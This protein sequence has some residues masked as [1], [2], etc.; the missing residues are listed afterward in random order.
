MTK[1]LRIATQ[2]LLW[3]LVLALTPL[4]V[5]SLLTYRMS[6]GLLMDQIQTNLRAIASNLGEEVESHLR[7]QERDL[8]VLAASASTAEALQAFGTAWT[9]GTFDEDAFSAAAARFEPFLVHSADA[10]GAD[11]IYLVGPDGRVVFS[12]A[13]GPDFGA[14]LESEEWRDTVLGRTANS[15]LVTLGIEQSDLEFYGPESV[16]ATFLASPVFSEGRLRGLIVLQVGAADLNRV[17][18][19]TTG[20]GETGEMVVVSE[21]NDEIVV[22]APTRH[23]PDAAFTRKISREGNQSTAIRESVDGHYGAGLGIDYRGKR[24]VASW[25]YLPALRWGVVVKIDADEAFAPIAALGRLST[26]IAAI[27]VVLA[28]VAAWLVARSFSRP[29]E[30]LTAAVHQV[31]SG[32]LRR[33]VNVRTRNEIGRLAEDFNQMTAQLREMVETMD[34][35]VRLRTAELAEARD[36]AEQANR[37]KSAFLANMSHELRTPMNAI[38]GYSEMLIEECED[39][40]HDEFVPDLQKIRSAGKH[41]L[42]LINDVL[43]LSKIEAGKMTIYLEDFAIRQ[44]LDEV[45]STIQPLIEKNDNRLELR[46]ASDLGSM[47]ADLTKVRQTL[48]NLLSN[49]SKFTEKGTVTLEV[50]RVSSPTGDRIILRVSDTGIG[51]T[52]E[53]LGKLFEAFTQADAST[54]RKYGGTGLGLAISREFCRMMG[55]DIT[56]ESELGKGSTFTVELPAEVAESAGQ[57]SPQSSQTASAPSAGGEGAILVI[58][59]DP[60]AADL[61]RR[62]LEKCGHRVLVATSGMEGLKMACEHKPAAITLDVM[63]PGMDGWSVL[64][65][66]KSDPATVDIPVVMVSLVRDKQ[67]GFTL[68][69]TDFLTKPV[70]ANQL[71][72][73]LGRLVGDAPGD[74]LVVE[75]D[76][77]SREMLVRLLGKSGFRVR[78]AENGALGLEAVA[79][80]R[81]A[82]ILLDLMMPVMDGF[83]FLAAIRQDSGMADIPVIIVTAKDLTEQDHQRLNGSAEAIIQKSSID[84]ATLL[85]RV[86]AIIG[87]K[88]H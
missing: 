36:L 39:L 43:D 14:D 8:N 25:Q 27:T 80:A 37:T 4:T 38:I 2:L 5:A 60:N 64:A 10:L 74:A 83:E 70:D 66:L 6:R 48:F 50:E 41:L 3:F 85:D 87:K 56:V 44:M 24:V 72:R 59:D 28:S 18:S 78:T 55:G 30:V 40:G 17:V 29:I 22:V 77:D 75:D 51:M 58:D 12:T 7:A 49:A 76:P 19:D 61:I 82:I 71:R 15:A 9:G 42:A 57:S 26:I 31:A 35:K 46:A 67:M 45:V 84:H 23:D 88:H 16:P 13:R 20:L 52:P 21:Q 73:T 47:R 62:S 54:T 33:T 86:Y 11:D 79:A 81:P 68:G 53:Q 69:A 1:P 34:E 63:M 65:A 32:N